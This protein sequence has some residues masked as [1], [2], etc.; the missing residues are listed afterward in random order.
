MCYLWKQRNK[1]FG[2]IIFFLLWVER[3]KSYLDKLVSGAKTGFITGS[4][5]EENRGKIQD[6]F[7]QSECSLGKFFFF[8]VWCKSTRTPYYKLLEP[9]QTGTAK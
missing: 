1:I 3:E 4:N 9:R 2:S 8:H 7:D 5:I 6:S